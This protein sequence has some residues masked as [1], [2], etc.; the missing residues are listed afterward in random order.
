M[1]TREYVL[2]DARD[3]SIHARTKHLTRAQAGIANLALAALGWPQIWLLIDNFTLYLLSDGLRK[4][5]RLRV[6]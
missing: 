4:R 3:C 5:A 1:E 2:W 6:N